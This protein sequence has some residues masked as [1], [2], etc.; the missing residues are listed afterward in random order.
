MF[1][2]YL[3]RSKKNGSLYIGFAP[4]LKARLIKHDQGLVQ[5]TKNIRPMNLVYF[6]GYKSK[7]DALL[8]EKRLKQFAQGF[9]SLK[10]RIINSL[11]L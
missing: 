8:R 7:E 3:L 9:A 10:R 5:S 1:Y 11:T 6:E 4:D 2:V